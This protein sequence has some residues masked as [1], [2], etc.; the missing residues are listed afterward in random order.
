[1]VLAVIRGD[2]WFLSAIFVFRLSVI[3]IPAT[4]LLT[5]PDSYLTLAKQFAASGTYGFADT[6]GAV[7]PT[8]F[9]PP[10]YPAVIALTIKFF[11]QPSVIAIGI[12]H[13]LL[14]TCSAAF[15]LLIG[16]RLAV[17][18]TS[19]VAI[20]FSLDPLLVRQSQLLM[21]ETLATTVALLSWWLCIQAYEVLEDKNSLVRKKS[22]LLIVAL[23]AGMSFG[24]ATLTRPTAIIWL[25]LILM[26]FLAQVIST[27]AIF[28][29]AAF[30]SM[31]AE[32]SARV[33]VIAAMLI[34]SMTIIAPWMIRNQ[35]T[36]GKPIWAT[37]H[38]GYTLLLANNPILYDHLASGSLSRDW[39]EDRFH[40]LWANRDKMDPMSEDFW[41]QEMSIKQNVA[42]GASGLSI[43][44]FPNRDEKSNE[45][46]N[47]NLNLHLHR[48]IIEDQLA[49][50]VAIATMRERPAIAVWSTVVRLGWL[51]TPLP[52]PRPNSS[53]KWVICIWYLGLY[54]LALLGAYKLGAA[55]KSLPWFIGW[56]LVLSVT[57]VHAVYWSNMR[58]RAPALPMLYLLAG[59]ALPYIW[60]AISKRKASVKP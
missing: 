21:T 5:D 16:R 47:N 48:E 42:T 54:G 27:S 58:M 41:H 23:I 3:A 18:Y 57:M 35:I 15:L 7:Q 38:G 28:T 52:N 39:D 46:S 10:L 9:R 36:I 60:S 44:P 13:S 8:A 11:G 55:N 12:L 49:Q 14:A 6:N 20:M 29:G 1:M 50:K 56:L 17:P 45:M 4:I 32:R 40:K 31:R 37:T 43:D 25:G 26:T 33:Q 51:W 59:W 34:G 24:I 53:S 22:L 2:W 19:L 30:T